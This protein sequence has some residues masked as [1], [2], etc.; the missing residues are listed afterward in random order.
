MLSIWGMPQTCHFLGLY[1][2]K[3]FGDFV[4]VKTIRS[5]R[6]V[7]A[8]LT[9]SVC[10]AGCSVNTATYGTGESVE[11]GLAKDIAGLVSFGTLGR[12][13]QERITY[14]ERAALVVPSEEQFAAIPEPIDRLDKVEDSFPGRAAEIERA[15]RAEEKK[16]GNEIVN[17]ALGTARS[18]PL[19]LTKGNDIERKGEL[20]SQQ[21]NAAVG[22]A[23]SVGP[24]ELARTPESIAKE[25]GVSVEELP[26]AY[27]SG[28]VR[29]RSILERAGLVQPKRSR[30]GTSLTDV[31]IE[32]RTVQGTET[33]P[34]VD[35]LLRGKKKKK[36]KRFLIF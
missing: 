22:T 16:G 34:E 23:G 15:K 11:L 20:D 35:Q 10:A 26:E 13:K 7:A 9:V 3:K 25:L 21:V 4:L 36:K 30:T 12:E 31:P 17:Q 27:K 28:T 19:N 33:D 5:A 24:E 6:F 1:V 29:E 32:Y 8:I 2:L 18:Q 14:R